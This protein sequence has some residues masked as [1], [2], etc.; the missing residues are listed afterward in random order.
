MGYWSLITEIK[1]CIRDRLSKVALKI[2]SAEYFMLAVFGL[3]IIAFVSGDS[4]IHGVISA[5]LGIFISTIGSDSVS[6]LTRFTFGNIKLM[7]GIK[8]MAVM[9]GMF[10]ISQMI[11]RIL[12]VE[13]GVMADVSKKNS[14]DV[15][16]LKEVKST[17]PTMLKSS[18][19]GAVVGAVPGTGG[20]IASFIAYNEAQRCAKKGE[21]FGEGELKGI[22]APES[23]NNGST[24]CTLIPLLTLGIPGDVVA[25]TLMGA[26]TMHGLIVGPRL[27]VTS[28]TTVYAILIGCVITQIFMFLQG[29][30]LLRTFVKITHIP[31]D[32]LTAL[33]VVVCCTGAFTINNSV[34]E[35]VIMI[36][37]GI[38][39]YFMK[40]IE[41]PTVPLVL[42]LVLGPTA[43]KH[44]RNMM[45]VSNGSWL[46]F[47]KRPVCLVLLA[48]IV[49]LLVFFRKNQNRNENV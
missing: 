31:K 5:A 48:L 44:L 7:S 18:A 40:K 38:A 35:V 16:T 37:S 9:L 24:C 13:E 34:V 6:G 22:A 23:A 15:L 39:A 41:L 1:M 47:F 20:G 36:I 45:V 10:A 12:G 17:V 33:L 4:I 30:Y 2:G 11:E 26:L 29:K 27:F 25:A 21:K 14:G 28:G 49:F 42:G 32:L 46:Y 3:T 43:E 8:M 19:I